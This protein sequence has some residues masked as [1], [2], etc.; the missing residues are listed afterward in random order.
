MAADPFPV[1]GPESQPPLCAKFFHLEQL[2]NKAVHLTRVSDQFQSNKRVTFPLGP[3]V[4]PE[5]L[6]PWTRFCKVGAAW[7]FR[8]LSTPGWLS[9]FSRWQLAVC[10]FWHVPLPPSH[11]L[12]PVVYFP[13]VQ[14]VVPSQARQEAPAW[15]ITFF[16]TPK[17]LHSL[18]VGPLISRVLAKAV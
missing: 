17:R 3:N 6:I 1:T 4:S 15:A 9:N 11:P 10:S 14:E 18:T 12:G 5:G 8:L 13:P 7:V 2:Y 16:H